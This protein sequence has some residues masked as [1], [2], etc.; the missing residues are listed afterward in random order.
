MVASRVIQVT[1][2]S[3]DPVWVDVSPGPEELSHDRPAGPLDVGLGRRPEEIAELGELP[4]FTEVV[5][6][7]VG[8]VHESLSRYKPVS[9]GV[10][11]GIEIAVRSGKALS[12]LAEA[13]GSAHVKVTASW[14][15]T[16]APLRPSERAPGDVG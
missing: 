11:F 1:L 4:G 8:S 3:G 9:I 6:G 13:G 5:Q 7:V 12:L 16:S 14:G 2:P 10:E 15:V